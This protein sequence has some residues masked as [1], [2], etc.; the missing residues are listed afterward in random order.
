[1]LEDPES[2]R[3]TF[4]ARRIPRAPPRQR[5]G[6]NSLRA[7]SFASWQDASQ[8]VETLLGGV[9]HRSQTHP[10]LKQAMFDFP[11]LG[12]VRYGCVLWFGTNQ[13]VHHRASFKLVIE[14]LAELAIAPGRGFFW[15]RFTVKAVHDGSPS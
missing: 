2:S 12:H 13:P 7:R 6:A 15:L 10:D 3:G 8:R 5:L 4:Y 14:L 11:V 1:M 9:S